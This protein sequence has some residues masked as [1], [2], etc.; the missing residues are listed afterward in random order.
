LL[1]IAINWIEYVRMGCHQVLAGNDAQ[2]AIMAVDHTEMA[3]TQ[4][5]KHPISTLSCN[6]LE[7]GIYI[8]KNH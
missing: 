6:K 5:T 1:K 4:S 8:S 3:E 7:Y 2:D